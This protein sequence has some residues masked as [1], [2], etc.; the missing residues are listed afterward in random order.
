MHTIIRHMIQK[1][2]DPSQSLVLDVDSFIDD[3]CSIA[4]DLWEHIR[5]LTQLVNERKGRKTATSKNSYASRLKRVRRA[6]LL[7]VVLFITNSECSFPFQHCVFINADSESFPGSVVYT[8]EQKEEG[9]L[10]F[11]RLIGTAYFSKY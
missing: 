10:A 2:P 7:S 5:I 8:A 6:Y 9:F 4:P 1:T 3:V 11:L